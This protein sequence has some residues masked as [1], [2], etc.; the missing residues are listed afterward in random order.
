VKGWFLMNAPDDLGGAPERFAELGGQL[1]RMAEHPKL[2]VEL[3]RAFVADDVRGFRRA[4]D[5]GGFGP[6]PDK[7]NPYITIIIRILRPPRLVERCYLVPRLLADDEVVA[8]AE[9]LRPGIDATTLTEL[10]KKFRLVVCHWEWEEQ[11]DGLTVEKFV[12]GVCPPGSF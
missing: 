8:M 12:Q 7:C 1:S 4:L 6:P 9:Q 3:H 2:L 5:R 11:D 10:F